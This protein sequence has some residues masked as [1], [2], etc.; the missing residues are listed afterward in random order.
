MATEK[1]KVS[2][3]KS[4]VRGG[5]GDL[6]QYRKNPRKRAPSARA[7]KAISLMATNGGNAGKAM[8][9]A[10]YSEVSSRSPSKLTQSKSFA[11]LVEEYLPD[12][13]LME[14]HRD[15]IMSPRTIRRIMK[16]QV[17]EEI[18]ET[19]PSQVRGL[20]MAYKLKGKYQNDGVTNNILIVQTSE[21]SSV[22]YK[23]E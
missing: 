3:A 15:V 22:R 16:G 2:I 7:I 23:P 10:G 12:M 21:T 18:E 9:E 14:K 4:S 20:D 19:D 11:S 1:K 8:R 13:L 5:T 6:A 17:I